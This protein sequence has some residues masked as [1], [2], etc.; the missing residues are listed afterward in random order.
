MSLLKKRANSL[1]YTIFCPLSQLSQRVCAHQSRPCVSDF[2]SSWLGRTDR[3][4]VGYVSVGGGRL[5]VSSSLPY[6]CTDCK[7]ALTMAAC[8]CESTHMSRHRHTLWL[9]VT[10]PFGLCSITTSHI[11]SAAVALS[12]L[13]LLHGSSVV[14][15]QT[16]QRSDV[17]SMLQ[18]RKSALAPRQIVFETCMLVLD[19]ATHR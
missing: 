3:L 19:V 13:P 10:W 15:P 4:D 8:A 7:Q 2:L 12:S 9:A 16:F 14:P 6:G 5:S 18:D 11:N 1:L 17:E